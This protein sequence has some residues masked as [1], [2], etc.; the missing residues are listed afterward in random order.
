MSL[1]K[2]NLNGNA[3]E[4]DDT[5]FEIVTNG[6]NKEKYLHYIGNGKNITNPKGN[7]SCYRMFENFRGTSLDLS[8][9]NTS[10]IINM[11]F[12]FHNCSNLKSL[13]LENFNTKNVNDMSGMFFNCA[14]L[15]I[16]DLSKFNTSKVIDMDSMFWFCKNLKSLNLSNFNT[17]NV[18]NM[19]DMFNKC[20]NLTELDLSSFHINNTTRLSDM[21]W[22]C[23]N[24][25]E[26]KVNSDFFQFF[27]DHRN[28][29]FEDCK[30]I[31]IIS[32]S[33]LDKAIEDLFY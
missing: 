16:L 11:S 32:V 20:K 31:T 24:I 22:Y 10:K 30:N 6:H 14:N 28:I 26:I 13:N 9:F 23:K 29:L 1:I 19:E 21:F 7:I 25:E 17:E 18:I 12:M 2:C 8:N 33:K 15:E 4:Y 3:V 27:S 5:E